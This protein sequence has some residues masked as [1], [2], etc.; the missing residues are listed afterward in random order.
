MPQARCGT[1]TAASSESPASGRAPSLQG[2]SES[3]CAAAWRMH[4]VHCSPAKVRRAPRQ[5]RPRVAHAPPSVVYPH[6]AHP[7][8]RRFGETCRVAPRMS[9]VH[10]TSWMHAGDCVRC[11]L[12]DASRPPLRP[13]PARVRST[14]LAALRAGASSRRRSASPHWPRSAASAG[15]ELPALSRQLRCSP[16]ERSL[17]DGRCCIVL[18]AAPPASP[19]AEDALPLRLGLPLASDPRPWSA[20]CPRVSACRTSGSR[21][22]AT[23]DEN[24]HHRSCHEQTTASSPV[25]WPLASEAGC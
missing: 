23:S 5:G 6:L 18:A 17:N 8:R 7:A 4:C 19:R 15:P 10:P 1:P 14:A 11:S 13:P 2:H 16:G 3:D 21:L 9:A 24:I 25:V 12:R 20:R 22:S